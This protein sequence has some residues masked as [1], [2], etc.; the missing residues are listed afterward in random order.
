[1]L[2]REFQPTVVSNLSSNVVFH[3]DFTIKLNEANIIFCC[4]ALSGQRLGLGLF[5][6]YKAA[7]MDKGMF[8]C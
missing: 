8:V 7:A 3:G 6:D 1:M 5:Y 2:W 4:L